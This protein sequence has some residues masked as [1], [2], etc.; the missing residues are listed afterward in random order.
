MTT[1]TA[2]ALSA[3]LFALAAALI[4]AFLRRDRRKPP[5]DEETQNA[6]WLDRFW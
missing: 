3:G 5:P 6:Q 2:I 1:T 4:A